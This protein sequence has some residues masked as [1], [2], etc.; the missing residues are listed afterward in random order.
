MNTSGLGGN[1]TI[2]KTNILALNNSTISTTSKAIRLLTQDR[3]LFAKAGNISLSANNFTLENGAAITASTSGIGNI[4]AGIIG[5]DGGNIDINVVNN[6]TLDGEKT[7][8][9]AR[10]DSSGNAGSLSV[11]SNNLALS[12]GAAIVVSTSNTGD[13]GSINLNIVNNFTLD[14][15]KTGLFASTDIDSQGKGG[16]IIVNPVN[17]ILLQNGAAISVNSAGTGNGGSISLTSNLLT[18][19]NFASISA[20]TSNSGEAGSISIKANNSTLSN[21]SKIFTTTSSSGNSGN[22]DVRV[23][24]NFTLDGEKTG[25]FANTT[26]GSSGNGGSIFVDPAFVLIQNSAAISVNSD[27]SGLG[28]NIFLFADRLTLNNN[29]AISAVTKSS[30]GGNV[31]LNVPTLLLMRYASLISATAGDSINGGNGG[32]IT[33][34]SQFVIANRF[35]NSDITANAFKGDGGLVTITAQGIFGLEFRNNLT[36]FSDITASSALGRS[37]IVTINTPG[38]DPSRG[39]TTLPL[40]LADPSKQVNQSCVIGGKLANRNNSF[41]ISGKGGVPKSPSDAVSSNRTLVELSDPVA[42]S[43]SQV[44][45]TEQKTEITPAS[46]IRLVEA[47]TI[48]R[49]NGAIELVSASAPLSPAIPQ[50]ACQ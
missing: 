43:I 48:I 29:A 32:N 23:I 15:E 22:I 50:L 6:F 11:Y 37:G 21:G 14:G 24:D 33:I 7:G 41:T 13:S 20:S 5:G 34:N 16:K 28:G 26:T 25:L 9:F 31:T 2:G 39:L 36:P 27:G 47:N 42:S 45:T 44:P 12:N 49:R 40:N 38:I 17:N 8:L 4:A 30:D 46:P 18:L 3:T 10:T 35:E 1:I 19:N